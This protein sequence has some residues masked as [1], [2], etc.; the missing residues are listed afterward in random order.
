MLS[1]AGL[2][3]GS[4]GRRSSAGGGAPL[5]DRH[6]LQAL[7]RGGLQQGTSEVNGKPT[8][9]STRRSSENKEATPI[10]AQKSNRWADRQASRLP[11]CLPH[12][13][14]CASHV[15]RRVAAPAA[16]T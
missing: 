15:L 1:V 10:A 4:A 14:H 12:R 11:T 2:L 3:G 5:L 8:I 16:V 7:Q 13:G 6:L 9:Q